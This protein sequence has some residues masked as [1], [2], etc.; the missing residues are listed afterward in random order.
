MRT[1][2]DADPT[3][4][5]DSDKVLANLPLAVPGVTRTFDVHDPATGQVIAQVPDFPRTSPS[6]PSPEPTQPAA[7]GLPPTPGTAPTSSAPGTTSS[8]T[9]PR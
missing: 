9:S 5:V 2:P 7:P 3:V 8:S 4:L 1:L 6:T